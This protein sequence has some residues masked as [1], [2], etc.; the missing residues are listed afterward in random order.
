MSSDQMSGRG[1]LCSED[2]SDLGFYGEML[3][4]DSGSSIIISIYHGDG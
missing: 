3:D 4:G 2:R 1:S